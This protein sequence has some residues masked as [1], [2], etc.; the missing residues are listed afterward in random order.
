MC[1][2]CT[3]R[4]YA[5][6]VSYRVSDHEVVLYYGT[7]TLEILRWKGYCSLP[8][9]FDARTS[10]VSQ[11]LIVSVVIEEEG[12]CLVPS[13]KHPPESYGLRLRVLFF[14]VFCFGF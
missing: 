13:V 6:G 12:F 7:I 8:Y 3:S 1:H 4:L 10:E 2:Y 11:T 14:F 5:F 9:F